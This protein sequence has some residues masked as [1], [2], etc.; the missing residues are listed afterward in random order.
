M[1][2]KRDVDYS[3]MS[4]EKRILLTERI[5]ISYPRL[6][7]IEQKIKHCHEF[8]KM[9]AEPV[10]LLVQGETGTGKTTCNHRYEK[11]FPRYETEDGTI[12]PVLSTAIPVPATVKSLVTKLLLKLGDPWAERGSVLNQTLRIKRLMK[13]CRVELI[14][15][16]EFQHFI[17]RDSQKILQTVSDWLKD[18]LNETKIPIVLI[19]MPNSER[20]L[21]ANRQLKRRFSVRINIDPFGW[22]TAEQRQDFRK[23]LRMVDMNLPLLKR[24]NLADVETA[25]RFF[26]ASDGIVA[27]V[28]QVARRATVLA[29]ERSMDKLDLSVLAE[30]YEDRLA[31]SNS[32]KEN[33][34]L[35]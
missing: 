19:G 27:N 30:A 14:I 32:K 28:M 4:A 34:F 16:D 13:A 35:A 3:R 9:S 6:T 23:F 17:D 11:K 33:P 31:M 8:S 29:I 18:L 12:V 15:L 25:F 22:E 20:I 5:H 2:E 10:N 7:E 1:M 24:S 26:H 21:E